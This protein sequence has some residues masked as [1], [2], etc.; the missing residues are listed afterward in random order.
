M[1]FRNVA[2]EYYQKG[3]KPRPILPWCANVDW[4]QAYS[5]RGFGVLGKRVRIMSRTFQL[6]SWMQLVTPSVISNSNAIDWRW[7]YDLVL[8]SSQWLSRSREVSRAFLCDI[9]RQWHHQVIMESILYQEKSV[10]FCLTFD[11]S[12]SFQIATTHQWHSQDSI[13]PQ[14]DYSL[15]QKVLSLVPCIDEKRRV[16]IN[17]ALACIVCFFHLK[18]YQQVPVYLH[19]FLDYPQ[20]TIYHW[21]CMVLPIQNHIV[22]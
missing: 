19:L 5:L 15:S 18:V 8:W 6:C 21:H 4:I 9:N 12:Y 20:N 7:N 14:L 11:H 13:C 10:I 16:V 3:P 1:V 22:W 2:R 17:Y